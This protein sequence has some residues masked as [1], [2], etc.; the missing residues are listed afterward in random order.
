MNDTTYEKLQYNEL[1]QIVKSYCVS[2]L[3][4]Q[5]I[6]KLKPNDNVKI[7]EIRLNET[8]EAVAVLNT[9]SRVPFL[10]VSNIENIMQRLEK[11]MILSLE[12]L[13]NISDFLRGC[14]K[15]K[16]YMLDKAF[17]A[18]ML[19]SYAN[20][21]T[22]FQSIEEE[23][24]F[25]VKGNQI[26]SSASKE[27]KRIRTNIQAAEVKVSE[28]LN[29]FLRSSVHKKYLQD[30]FISKKEERY[31]IPIKAAY[32]HHVEGTIIDTSA[33]GSTVFIEPAVIS[34]L[35]NALAAL[36]A[37]EQ[38]E[39]YQILATLSGM[40]LENIGQMKINMELIGQYDMVFAKAKYSKQID[41]IEPK[42]ND[43][44]YIKLVDCKHPLLSGEAVPLNL[45]IGDDFRS[46][47]ITGPNAGGKTI[48]LKSIGLLTLA[49]MSGFHIDAA[50]GTEIGLF[51]NIFVD[52]GD[53]QSIDNALSTF[54]SHM[55]NI[56]DIMRQANNRSLLLFDEIG[57]GTEPNE[58]AAL[59]ISILE[60]F[61]HMGCITVATTHYG[62]IKRFSEMH[63]DFMNAAMQFNSDT[64]EPLYKLIL[65]KSGD[66]NALWISQKMNIR[67]HVLQ[68]A[69]DYMEN[70]EY[71]LKIISKD[72]IHKPKAVKKEPEVFYGYEKGDRVKLLEKDDA[73]IVY[74]GAD[75]YHNVV[76]FYKNEFIKVNIKRLSLE[77]KA[78]DLYPEGYDLDALFV[79]YHTR[80]MDYDLERGSKKALRNIEKEIRKNRE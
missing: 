12:D 73:G 57:S 14:R 17:I 23:I 79:D 41:G 55:Q 13:V 29:R 76:V 43:H 32:K 37:E 4:K 40:I 77:I 52:I 60:E 53:N 24:N 65:G 45:E 63:P 25:S 72:K 68:K 67:E 8:T 19:A 48:V 16:K 21:M 9:N 62:E 38:M 56:S 34:K 47:I 71:N 61:Y 2:G 5:L 3:G 36:K 42:L 78:K 20:S 7:V 33:K 64:L 50:K 39:E 51:E 35:N 46:L 11:G 80:K 58:G 10:G 22:E 6:D 26:D 27:L 75:N 49:V 31:T 74:Q 30:T 1:K 69:K 54:S 18:P 28:R 44:G 70:K 66:S 15:I 59:A